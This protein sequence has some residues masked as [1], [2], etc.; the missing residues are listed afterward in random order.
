MEYN[1]QPEVELE[2]SDPL[3]A[4]DVLDS[5]NICYTQC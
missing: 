5:I 2:V 1:G 3:A 4:K